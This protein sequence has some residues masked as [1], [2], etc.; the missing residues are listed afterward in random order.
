M[1]NSNVICALMVFLSFACCPVKLRAQSKWINALKNG[2]DLNIVVYGTSLTAGLPAQTWVSGLKDSLNTRYPG[3]VSIRNSAQVA[4]HSDWGVSNLKDRVLNHDPDV[5]FIEFAVNDA[6]LSYQ[7]SLRASALNLRYM[8]ERIRA[9]KPDVQVVLQIM[10][11]PTGEH[12]RDRPNFE[13][14]YAQYKKIGRQMK[15]KVVDHSYWNEI[16]RNEQEF[17]RWVPDGIHPSAEASQKLILPYLL[18]QLISAR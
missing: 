14:Y 10:N 8:I 13:A 7:I 12:L 15:V 9:W 11:P 4:M 16:A 6:F 5:V 2:K 1:K 18:K 3:K 17:L